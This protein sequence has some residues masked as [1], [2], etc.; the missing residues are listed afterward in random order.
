MA[1][2]EWLS[3]V[4]YRLSAKAKTLA[5]IWGMDADKGKSKGGA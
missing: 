1:N 2:G 3:V 4:S 5:A